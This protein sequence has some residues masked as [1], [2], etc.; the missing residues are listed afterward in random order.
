MPYF[1]G[2]AGRVYY[3]HWRA[4]RP[5][6]QV[7]FLHGHGEHGGHYHRFA[8]ALDER[9]ISVWGMDL[10]GHG[11]S[12]GD[13]GVVTSVDDLARDAECLA[14]LARDAAPG[15]PL[16]LAGHSLGGVSSAVV[17]SR[18]GRP[19]AALVLTGTPLQSLPDLEAAPEMSRDPFYLDA[20]EHD[21]LRFDSRHA[22]ATLRS[23]LQPAQTMIAERLP[24]LDIPVL[25]VN[26]TEDVFAP[27]GR[28]E[29]LAARM[30]RARVS[31]YDGA[32][33]DIVNDTV[34]RAVAREIADF[35]IENT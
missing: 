19:Y 6:A 22:D 11:L 29:A 10:V 5:R 1:D 7:V 4:E 13:R 2:S 31:V 12:E 14:T 28:A 18:N 24:H 8:A 20:L 9:S 26:G 27:P 21:P 30:S 34:H 32:R 15:L 35:V 33:H 3:R 25:F 16:V 17:A 23:A